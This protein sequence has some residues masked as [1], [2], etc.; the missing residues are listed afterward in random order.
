MPSKQIH[1]PVHVGFKARQNVMEKSGANLKITN[2]VGTSKGTIFE[3]TLSGSQDQISMAI[4]M[5]RFADEKAYEWSQKKRVAK[6]FFQNEV[7]SEIKPKA[8][9][10]KTVRK[11][12]FN[13]LQVEEPVE[14]EKPKNKHTSNHY[15]N[16]H[17]TKRRRVEKEEP[18]KV[19][20]ASLAASEPKQEVKEPEVV[21][22]PK[23][24]D[25]KKLGKMSWA[26]LAEL[27]FE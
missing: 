17:S 21:E 22:A 6:Q 12:G 7:T 16:G 3:A 14:Q 1:F 5:I 27:E 18:K 10:P 11:T 4:K 26:E 9:K 25:L 15:D 23:K 24:Q 20:W 2:K 19:S 13:L 8:S